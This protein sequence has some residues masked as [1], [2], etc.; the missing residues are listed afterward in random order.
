MAHDIAM[1]ING[2]MMTFTAGA[3]PWHNLGQNVKD[4]QTWS[5]A[6]KLAQLDWQ[7]I[8]APLYTNWAK[9][10]L[11]PVNGFKAVVRA[12][13]K[14]VLGVHGMDYRIFQN[15]D[16]FKFAD[17]LIE[18]GALFESA[19]GLG[20][21]ERIWCLARIPQ[22]DFTVGAFD[23]HQTFLLVA[24]SHDGSLAFTSTLTDV[25]VVCNNTL[26]AALGSTNAKADGKLKVRHT[27]RGYDKLNQAQQL[28]QGTIQSAESLKDKL[29]KL[30]HAPL[31]RE[32]LTAIVD[33]LFPKPTDENVSTTR[34]DRMLSSVLA[35]FEANDRNYFPEQ[36]G[37]AYALLN[38][39]TDHTDH[40]RGTRRPDDTV[41]E[42]SA[43][44]E[45]AL[46]GSGAKL[47]SQA[48]QVIYQTM[49]GDSLTL[50]SSVAVLDMPS[51][52]D[53]IPGMP[54]DSEAQNSI[55]DSLFGSDGLSSL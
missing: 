44:A 9:S 23:T 52:E 39:I 47:K 32:T 8:D 36:R 34:R 40:E 37:T 3:L 4:A 55:L 17:G 10:G 49:G 13:T 12:D 53:S 15:S 28:I 6:I 21:G 35:K 11:I 14:D 48:L 45:S 50:P 16:A 51:D 43:R 5:E 30:A 2:K 1:N 22:A 26:T 24:T 29:R 33:R 27:S 31:T 54:S 38:A 7:V 20:H 25:R 41:S 19:G 42:G 18:E 46:F